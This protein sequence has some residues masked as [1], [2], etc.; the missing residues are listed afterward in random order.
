MLYKYVESLVDDGV[1][2]DFY[3]FGHRHL[4]TDIVIGENRRLIILGDWVTNFSFAEFDGE[5]LKLKYYK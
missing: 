2:A 3:I 1:L 5:T 4:P